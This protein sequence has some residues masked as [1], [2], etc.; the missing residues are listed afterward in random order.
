M[1]TPENED[2]NATGW[3]ESKGFPPGTFDPENPD[4][5]TEGPL[6]VHPCQEGF[7]PPETPLHSI[8]L[9]GEAKPRKTRPLIIE[10][11]YH[12]EIPADDE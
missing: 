3:Y 7:V 5:I 4:P 2:P 9:D 1:T 11:T 6:A 12:G 8:S 10:G